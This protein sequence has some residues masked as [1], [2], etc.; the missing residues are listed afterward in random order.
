MYEKKEG[1]G[2]G[3]ALYYTFVGEKIT[4]RLKAIQVKERGLLLTYMT[5]PMFVCKH[6]LNQ[7]VYIKAHGAMIVK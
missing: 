2:G 5:G 3:L 7:Y 6:I 4:A 1:G